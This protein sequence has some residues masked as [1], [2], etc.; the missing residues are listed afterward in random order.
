VIIAADLGSTNFKAAVF[1]PDGRRLGEAAEPLVYELHTNH[2]A[3]I[4]PDIVGRTFD[5]LVRRTLEAAALPAREVTR[6]ALTSQAQ[7]FCVTD[8]RGLPTSPFLSWT[9][10]RALKEAAHLQEVLGPRVHCY[11]GYPEVIAHHVLAKALWWKNHRTL[12]AGHRLATLPSW[13]AGRLGAPLVL[14]RNLAA[15]TGCFSIPQNDWWDE[16]LAAAGLQPAQLGAV[17]APG[18]SVPVDAAPTS[19]P[20]LR[21]VVFA[22]NDHTAGAFGCGCS[23]SRGVLTIGTAGVFYRLAGDAPGP[24]SPDGLW[25]PYPAGGSYELHVMPHACSALDWA[26]AHL[27]GSVDSRRFVERARAAAP[28]AGGV[29]FDPAHWGSTKAWSGRGTPCEM[30]RAALEGITSALTA[31]TR[32]ALSNVNE[33]VVLGGGS[34]LD[35]WV[36][37][38]A[39]ATGRDLVR[40]RA[41]GLD[42]AAMMAHVPVREAG[43]AAVATFHPTR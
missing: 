17:V 6:V 7:T 29:T 33:I 40:L 4:S 32:P 42:G 22:G 15:M 31:I 43:R 10:T 11:T 23:T 36:Q 34:R 13:L 19:L 18:E 1:A 24:F 26:D 25:G 39:D 9:D 14:D 8:D 5:R 3:E 2:R 12:T 21:S 20:R 28:G 27:F 35:F 30:A 16:A 41:D 38:I 37:M